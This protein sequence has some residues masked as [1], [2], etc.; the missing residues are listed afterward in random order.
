MWPWEQ[1]QGFLFNYQGDKY[2]ES[3]CCLLDCIK[4][5]IS[6]KDRV[7]YMHG[8]KDR[9][10]EKKVTTINHE[11]CLKVKQDSSISRVAVYARVSTALDSQEQSYETQRQYYEKFVNANDGMV[12][13]DVYGD[14]GISGLQMNKRPEFQRMMN[15]A[16]A[17]KIDVII[18]KSVSRFSR[19]M[20][21]CVRAINELRE[22]GIS[23]IFEKEGIDSRD[24]SS[25]LFF[26]ILSTL[27]Q[28]ESNS[29]S[30]NTVWA[31]KNRAEAGDPIRKA[32]YGY[33]RD[34][35]GDH[36]W[37][38][39]EPEAR[40]V[41]MAFNMAIEGCS[42]KEI[43]DEL[44]TLEETEQTGKKWNWSSVY[45]MFNNEAYK[46]DILTHKEI[47][48]DYKSAHAV[49]NKS[50]RDQ[51]YLEGHH[52]AIVDPKI[53]DK[54][55]KKMSRVSRYGYRISRCDDDK[56][57]WMIYEP[58][59]AKVRLAFSMAIDGYS[60]LEIANALNSFESGIDKKVWNANML[61]RLFNNEAYKGDY[62]NT[63]KLRLDKKRGIDVTSEDYKRQIYIKNH[64]EPI[65]PASC[66][67][68]V[69]TWT[70]NN[71]FK[72]RSYRNGQRECNFNIHKGK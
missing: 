47:K 1:S 37:K 65:V 11:P 13:V 2:N 10:M 34:K 18:T 59:A 61:F 43:I 25:E 63:G 16:R 33:R 62:Q 26:Y 39:Y 55:N 64:H 42:Y 19:N 69:R 41:R 24:P 31:H 70:K 35:K 46:G 72:R 57:E 52:E 3:V 21:Q 71:E 20:S 68:Q 53:Y 15:D 67:D 32:C 54:L 49:K 58:E 14:K 23:V 12:L 44:N 56:E 50:Y 29:I 27:A 22:L 7:M 8:R 36:E 66:F 51:Y 30:M 6:P 28:E 45:R 48:L 40:K 5:L 17:G 38:I 4:H 60:Y 9:T